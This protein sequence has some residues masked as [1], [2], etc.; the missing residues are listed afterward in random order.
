MVCPS[1]LSTIDISVIKLLFK[2]NLQYSSETYVAVLR[3]RLLKINQN[4][5]AC[6]N[7]SKTKMTLLQT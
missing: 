2:R 4:K 7:K 1:K 3:M 6:Y 5:V